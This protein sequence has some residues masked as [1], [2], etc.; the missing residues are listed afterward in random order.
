MKNFTCHLISYSLNSKSTDHLG[1]TFFL[2]KKINDPAIPYRCFP[3]TPQKTSKTWLSLTFRQKPS[4]C[5][6]NSRNL[7]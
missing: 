2:K 6:G 5:V 3:P 4:S 7:F 1:M